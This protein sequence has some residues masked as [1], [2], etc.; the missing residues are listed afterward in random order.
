M[1]LLQKHIIDVRCSSQLFG[2]EIQNSLSDILEKDFY[3]K[4]ELILDQYSIKNYEWEI[5]NLSID[6]PEISQKEWKKELVNQ[7]LFKIEEYLKDHFP[8]LEL[9]K[10]KE[11]LEDFGFESQTKFA[12]KLFFEFLKTGIIAENSYSKNI[13]KIAEAIDISEHFIEGIVTVFN[14]NKT[15][16]IRFYFNSKDSFKE[17]VSSEILKISTSK[18]SFSQVLEAFFNSKI[19][20]SS[21]EELENWLENQSI[22]PDNKD[23][24]SKDNEQD[25]FNENYQNRKLSKSDKALLNEEDLNKTYDKELSIKKGE[26]P[27]REIENSVNF[28]EVNDQNIHENLKTNTS[29]L[30]TSSLYI[31]NAGLVILHPF[32]LNLFQKL[33]LYKDEVW[34]DKESQ[35]KAVLLTQYL[36]TGQEVFFE[37][38]LIL[39]KLICGFPIESVINTKQK[40]SKEEKE[41]CN[42]LLLVVLEYWSVMK[43]SSVE[44]LRETFLQRAGKL[45][46]SETHPSELWVEE[47][48][49]D[50]L[51][52]SLPWG[53]GLLQTPWMNNFLHCYWN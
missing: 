48:G 25:H 34:I 43:N 1:H 26:N 14:E 9:K 33:D 21:V 23:L 28:N 17:K 27:E 22:F 19:K 16:L 4:L 29:E 6:L 30:Q 5:E 31:D 49:V 45:S 11:D 3:P 12:E 41:I 37:N 44:A 18:Q 36:V 20:F 8:V 38:E 46:L 7:I 24:Q 2:K 53:I 50:V 35:H 15:A 13:D 51:L 10:N 42:D 32:L 52:A 47:K 40:I 39:N